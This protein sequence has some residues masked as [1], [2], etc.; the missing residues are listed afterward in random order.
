MRTDPAVLFRVSCANV[1][2][3][4]EGVASLWAEGIDYVTA[5]VEVAT[6]RLGCARNKVMF[7]S[8]KI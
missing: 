6:L 1:L 7:S 8:C 3:F 2:A 4:Y 5:L